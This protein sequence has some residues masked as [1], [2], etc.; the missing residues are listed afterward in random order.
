MIPVRCVLPV[1]AD[2]MPVARAVNVATAATAV[3]MPQARRRLVLVMWLV[4]PY[5][6]PTP[7]CGRVEQY[8]GEDRSGSP[9]G[10]PFLVSGAIDAR[11][12]TGW[13]AV[14]VTL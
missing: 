6:R 14:K 2:A 4:L 11:I 10:W 1:F 9:G 8:V 12:V 13:A 3:P 7:L 5:L